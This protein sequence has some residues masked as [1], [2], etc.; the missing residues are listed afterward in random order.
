MTLTKL[1]IGQ[2]KKKKQ[3]VFESFNVFTEYT[4]FKR[5]KKKKI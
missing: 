5:E 3:I 4:M 1:Y 2:K